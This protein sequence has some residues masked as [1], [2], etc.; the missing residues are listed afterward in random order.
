M[1]G[2]TGLG[3]GPQEHFRSCSDITIWSDDYESSSTTSTSTSTRAPTP[4]STT[5]PTP[6][7]TRAPNPDSTT[8]STPTSTST[9]APTRDSTAPPSSTTPT[10]TG[11][12]AIGLYAGRFDNWCT[13]NCNHVPSFCPPTYCKCT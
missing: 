13:I 9:R 2:E 4:D 6:T 11:C 1:T 3:L 12:R 8:P 10:N 5:P 7:S